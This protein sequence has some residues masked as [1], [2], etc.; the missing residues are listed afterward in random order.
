MRFPYIYI[1]LCILIKETDHLKHL[2]LYFGETAE[3]TSS[4]LIHTEYS[5][6][7]SPIFVIVCENTAFL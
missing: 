7:M 6:I 3:N 1:V 4:L 2:Y 5:H